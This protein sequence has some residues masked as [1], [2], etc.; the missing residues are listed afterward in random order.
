MYLA[1]TP[2]HKPIH[3]KTIV[4]FFI[5]FLLLL[6]LATKGQTP[7]QTIR[8]TVLD[9]Q[10]QSQLPG[11][12]VLILGSNPIKGTASDAEGRFKITEVPIGR[13]DLKI[14]YAGY[15]EIVLPNVVVTSGKEVVLDIGMEENL[16]SLEE[17]VVAGTKKN[18]T[19]NEMVSVSGRSFSME[20]VNRYAGGRSDPSR[21]AANFAGVSSPDD[22]RNDIVIRGN[23]PTGV[24][25]RIEGLNI[26]NPNHF[27]TVGTTGGPVSAINTNVIK[28]SDFFT[29]A[30]P[31][32]YGN[33]N[34]GVFDLGFRNGNSE[35]YE[36][37]IQLGALTGLEAMTEGPINKQKGSSYLVAYRYSFTGVA[38][39]TGIPIGT[40]ATPFY[41]DLSFK[42][43]GGQTKLGKFTFFGLGARSKIEFLHDKIDSTDLFA[44]PTRDSYFTSDIGLAGLK[45]FIKLNERSYVNTIIGVTYNG[46]NYLEDRVATDIKPL[47]R[48][49]EN[50]TAQLRY[51]INTSYNSKISSKLFVK[52]G[53]ISEAI[54]LMLNARDRDSNSVWNQYWDFNDYTALH[55]AYAQ[56]KYRFTEKLT[57]NL[58]VHGQLLALNNSYAIEPRAGLKYQLN[59]KHSLSAGYGMHSQMQPIDA[60]FYRSPMVDGTYT[61]S[62]RELGF[63]KSQHFVI[64]YDV[65]P[66]TDWR[67]KTE[68]YFQMLSNVP[69]SH[70]SGS[71]SMLNNGASFAY[72]NSANLVNGGTGSNYGA[73]LTIEKFFSKGY[74]VLV[75]G[76]VYES[77]YKGSDGIER[78]TAFNGKFVYNVLAGKDFKIGREKRHVF[79]IGVKLTQAG[80]RYYT[81]V[82][83]EASQAMNNQV[84]QGDDYAFSQ[85]NPDFFRLDVKTGFTFNSKK[86]KLSQSIYF[87]IQNVTNNKNVFA[88]R[89]N[90]VTN[91]VNTA[92]QI[93]FFPNFVYK[94][95]F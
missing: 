10:S 3:M 88:Q 11:A 78:N 44:N 7:V 18:E 45:H 60:Y 75:T 64:G 80:G 72:V 34:A 23:S 87:D 85:R 15:K 86:I 33:A 90:P 83:L 17:V 26:P 53:I 6:S 95:Q 47:E 32:E 19:Q 69:I 24:L 4:F 9:K 2:K 14:S 16:N 35:K 21:L 38:Q 66:L 54:N 42:I 61:M 74:Y 1:L 36:H 27:S 59:E 81:P 41:Q 5:T 22:S 94:V 43:N 65:L 68:V 56:A 39:A 91:M 46:S 25:W 62:N 77:K 92:Y 63:T 51:S 12:N 67:I 71:Y 57:L 48:S 49:V 28:N 50:K 76:T 20:E 73:E 30:F 82:D 37:T 89:Y 79:N 31:A 93:G 70:T 40:A 52:A 84:L 8:G 58:G 29:S 55:Q 13:Y